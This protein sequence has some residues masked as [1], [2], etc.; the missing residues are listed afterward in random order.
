MSTIKTNQIQHTA[1]G[2]VPFTLPGSDGSAGQFMKTDGSGTLSFGSVSAPV[3]KEQFMLSCDGSS[4]STSNGTFTTT[5][6]T[7]V[8]N[9]PANNT[10]TFT[11]SE[12]S[13]Q[14]PTGTTCVIY[15]FISSFGGGATDG[16]WNTA[17]HIDGTHILY[18]T[19]TS[20][21]YSN[22]S[23]PL[24]FKWAINIGGTADNNT[25]RQASWNSAKTLL[26][27]VREYDANHSQDGHEIVHNQFGGGAFKQPQIGITA[28]G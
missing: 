6:V 4:V 27:R 26:L 15:E 22:G 12:I 17:L 25:G 3:V 5:N 2:A 20:R 13:Y 24:H 9:L 8:Q 18:S 14:P 10:T 16:I 11:G 23:S 7:A 21:G 28:I 1:N 19:L